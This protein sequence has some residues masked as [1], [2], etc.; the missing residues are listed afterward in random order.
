MNSEQLYDASMT[1]DSPGGEAGGPAF[2]L[3]LERLDSLIATLEAGKI[4][5]ED[6]VKTYQ[7]A[8]KLVD[9]CTA[10]LDRTQATITQLVSGPQGVAEAPIDVEDGDAAAASR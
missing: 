7:Q 4:D 8:M 6:S 10:L 3:A 1:P 2:E 9:H 5:L